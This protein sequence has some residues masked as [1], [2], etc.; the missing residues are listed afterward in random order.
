MCHL[1]GMF[2]IYPLFSVIEIYYSHPAPWQLFQLSGHKIYPRA[3]LYYSA[4]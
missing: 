4:L 1:E 2:L 3:M